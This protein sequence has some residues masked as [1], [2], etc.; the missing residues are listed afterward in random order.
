MPNPNPPH[1][2]EAM[3]ALRTLIDILDNVQGQQ[4]RLQ[5]E[6]SLIGD[7]LEKLDSC[8]RGIRTILEDTR[9]TGPSKRKNDT[10][11]L[12]EKRPRKEPIITSKPETSHQNKTTTGTPWTGAWVYF[13]PFIW[14]KNTNKGFPHVLGELMIPDATR[15]RLCPSPHSCVRLPDFLFGENFTKI[16]FA[17]IQ[18]AEEFV[19]IWCK[20]RPRAYHMNGPTP[21]HAVPPHSLRLP[22]T[23]QGDKAADGQR[24]MEV[25]RRHAP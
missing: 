19:A 25:T 13:G 4:R 15:E 9:A 18:N 14:A 17:D 10:D 22:E 3:L 5:T 6:A 24:E 16:H 7:I 2:P 11:P 8:S 20:G 1:D 23:C 12:P 21:P